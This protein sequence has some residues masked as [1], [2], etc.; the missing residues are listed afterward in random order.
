MSYFVVLGAFIFLYMCGWFCF[1]VAE[2]RNDLADTAWGIGFAALCW[3]SYFLSQGSWRAIVVNV[4][5]TIW[6]L[7]LSWHVWNRNRNKPEDFRYH[8]W[9]KTWYRFYLRSFL[10]IFMLQGLLLYVVC[11]PALLVNRYSHGIGFTALDAAGLLIWL[12]GFMF[13]SVGDYQLKLFTENPNNRGKIMDKGLWRY[14][15]HPNYFGEIAMWWGIG[16]ITL[17][18]PHGFIGLIGP[19]T[20]TCLILFVSGIPMLEEHMRGKPG[21]AEYKAKTS[22]LIPWFRKG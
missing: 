1:A 10:Q 12:T 14:S 3:F 8:Q 6:G 5:I 17:S 18:V 9:R 16:I 13:E 20:I 7:R 4:L 22:L 21:W 19:A 11:L 15:R 2:K